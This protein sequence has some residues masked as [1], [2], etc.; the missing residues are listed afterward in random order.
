MREPST[1]G[2]SRAHTKQKTTNHAIVFQLFNGGAD[3]SFEIAEE[4]TFKT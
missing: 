1:A 2:E 3:V 4:E